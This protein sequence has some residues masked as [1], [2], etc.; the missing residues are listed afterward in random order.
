MFLPAIADIERENF[1]LKEMIKIALYPMLMTL[2]LMEYAEGGS[3]FDVLVFGASTIIA[4]L[5]IYLIAPII[6]VYQLRKQLMKIRV[7][8]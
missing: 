4:N 3:E 5:G 1:I 6:V 8:Q 7:E 2:H